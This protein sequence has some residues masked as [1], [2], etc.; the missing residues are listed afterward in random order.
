[1]S[2][3]SQITERENKEFA[4]KHN[5]MPPREAQK[6]KEDNSRITKINEQL[7]NSISFRILPD[8]LKSHE[9]ITLRY[10][11]AVLQVL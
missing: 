8:M 7:Q 6:L 5:Y 11:Y 2:G 1:L 9:N 4:R 3:Q 10:S